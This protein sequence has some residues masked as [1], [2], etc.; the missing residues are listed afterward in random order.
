MTISPQVIAMLVPLLQQAL[1]SPAASAPNVTN[2]LQ[3]GYDT[4][5]MNELFQKLYNNHAADGVDRYTAIDALGSL[6]NQYGPRELIPKIPASDAVD[7]FNSNPIQISDF[8]AKAPSTGMSEEDWLFNEVDS[9]DNPYAREALLK[10][11]K[12]KR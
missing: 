8:E 9:A 4:G 3:N 11:I 12:N 6:N 2:A 7:V 5:I 10:K 1:R